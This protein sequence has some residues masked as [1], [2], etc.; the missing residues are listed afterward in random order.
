M[1]QVFLRKALT[2]CTFGYEEIDLKAVKE[3]TVFR[4]A[5]VYA[6]LLPC[7]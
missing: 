6:V 4:A 1:V 2:N 3:R 5:R 7:I